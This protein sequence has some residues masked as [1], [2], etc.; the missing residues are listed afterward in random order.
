M[1]NVNKNKRAIFCK[2]GFNDSRFT[3]VGGADRK[4]RNAVTRLTNCDPQHIPTRES[5]DTHL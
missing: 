2:P 1:L 5:Q 4:S 3:K